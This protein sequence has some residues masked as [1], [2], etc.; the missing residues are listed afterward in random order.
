VS[1]VEQEHRGRVARYAAIVAAQ[2]GKS[3]R[4]SMVRL[5]AFLAFAVLLGAGLSQN[6]TVLTVCA[7]AMV[8]FWPLLL[9]GH[10]RVLG[11]RDDA[12]ARKE[13]HE[14]HLLRLEGKS[15]ELP[16]SGALESPHPY[17]V[18]V[19]LVGAA[20]LAQRID[21]SHTVEGER[22]LSTWLGAPARLETIAARQAAVAELAEDLDFRE[23]LEATATRAQGDAR[24]DPSPFLKFVKREPLVTGVLPLVI[25]V[26][27]IAVVGTLVASLLELVPHYVFLAVLGAQVL[28]ALGLASRAIDAFQLIAARRG[29]AESL[30][31][32][33]VLI[34]EQSFDAPLL[35]ELR[36]RTK[37]SGRAPSSYM[38]RLDRWAG[39]AEFYTQFPIHFFVNLATLYDLH[40]LLRLERWN[41]DVGKGLEDAFGAVAELEAL[42]SL[43]TLKATDPL[44]TFP[45][46]V[47]EPT[48]LEA[49]GL[50]HPLLHPSV[51]VVNDV[52]VPRHGSVLIVTG[53][54]MAG[55]STLLRAVGLNVAL[56][57]CGAPVVASR[58]KLS[59]VRLRASMRVDDSLQEGAS[60][61]HA[62]LTKLRGVVSDAEVEPPVFFLLDELLRGTNARARHLGARAV[63]KHLLD[64]NG[65][66]LAATH[67]VALAALEE[68]EPE[69]AVN[70]HFTDVMKG[71]EMTFDYRLR[72][73]VVKTSNALR[74]LKLAGVDV[75]DDDRLPEAQ[76]LE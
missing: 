40:V 10:S 53:S 47:E 32:M 70:V 9:L 33:L 50:G 30:R 46:V 39:F 51:R 11:K 4:L 8:A 29:Y 7:F 36:A 65:C 31:A 71:D 42:A 76:A 74:L 64:R 17:A 73:G 69:R 44:A 13:V 25:H 37:V 21:V 22:I 60:Y 34:E 5:L 27:P 57:L 54:N 20:S 19:D 48:P 18:D 68:E 26:F 63:L 28:L 45:D 23:S 59:P 35:K 14:R 15:R 3:L 58:F 38:A 43:A 67:D 16:V 52:H 61:F 6:S 2:E 75:P 55:K 56:A 41:A 49:E 72:P 12:A 62:E 66:G 1:D 24:L